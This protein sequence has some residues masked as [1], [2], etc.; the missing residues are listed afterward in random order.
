MIHFRGF[1]HNSLPVI[2]FHELGASKRP[3]PGEDRLC[4]ACAHGAGVFIDSMISKTSIPQN[5]FVKKV[6]LIKELKRRPHNA[7][8]FC[9]VYV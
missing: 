7:M 2:L 4:T 3:L 1:L 9:G 6:R 8:L 5:D